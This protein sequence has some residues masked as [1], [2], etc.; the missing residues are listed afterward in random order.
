MDKQKLDAIKTALDALDTIASGPDHP[1]R[2]EVA[3]DGLDA[4]RDA[5]GQEPNGGSGR[6]PM[7]MDRYQ[8]ANAAFRIDGYYNPPPLA[9]AVPAAFEAARAECLRNM[10]A[11]VERVERLSWEQFIRGRKDRPSWWGR[12][13][14]NTELDEANDEIA[15]MRQ[16]WQRVGEALG[17]KDFVD[18]EVIIAKVK[19][20]AAEVAAP[21]PQA[22]RAF[23][24]LYREIDGDD[25]E[26]L[27][28]SCLAEDSDHAEEQCLD[29]Q[30][31]IELVWS[32]EGNS[33][34][35]ALESYHAVNKEDLA[36]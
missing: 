19:E 18:P 29:A 22:L 8:E 16:D 12:C 35:A 10:R 6:E 15:D 2:Q 7:N 21:S 27:G 17:F 5:F 24:V 3:Q 11:D 28:F 32:F 13:K 14:P 4:L 30:E 26:P 36:D 20:L 31:G 1:N 34:E 25:D 9:S 23:I 33:L